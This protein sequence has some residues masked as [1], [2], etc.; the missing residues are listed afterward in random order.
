MISLSP[1]RTWLAILLLLLVAAPAGAQSLDDP[2]S[3]TAKAPDLY[4]VQF[5]TTAGAFTIKVKRE[6]AP[7]GADRFYNLAKL[8]FYDDTAF[9]RVIRG[10]MVQFGLNGDP[11]LS[12]RWKSAMIPDD[13]VWKSNKKGWVTF[14]MSGPNT[15]TTQIF[16]N[17]ANNS[18]LD[19]QG[20]APF[21]KVV[22]GMK[23]VDNLYDDYGEGRP[24]GMGPDQTRVMLQGSSYLRD[25]YPRL[26]W[27]EKVTVL[28]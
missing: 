4:K 17:Y 24:R 14:A 20:F 3:A 28:E 12:Q 2:S 15:R 13:G 8:G 1:L 18:T 6:W 7:S 11:I 23:V 16:V 25:N 19:E 10:F 21:G 9:F 22:S 27:I 26:D 5:E